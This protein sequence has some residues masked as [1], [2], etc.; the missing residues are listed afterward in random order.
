MGKCQCG[1]HY[2]GAFLSIE[3]SSTGC[4]CLFNNIRHNARVVYIS[5][6]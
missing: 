4:I 3:D 1:C 5:L 2:L 6:V